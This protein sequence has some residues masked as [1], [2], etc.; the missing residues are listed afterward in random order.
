MLKEYELS[1]GKGA[2]NVCNGMTVMM[3][4]ENLAKKRRKG[5]QRG[6]QIM[7]KWL[8]YWSPLSG[9]TARVTKGAGMRERR[10]IKQHVGLEIKISSCTGW[11]WYAILNFEQIYF[12]NFH[13]T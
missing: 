11:P 12:L 13:G 6:N 2:E 4:H 10:K 8:G 7:K 9:R 3:D 1:R 5:I